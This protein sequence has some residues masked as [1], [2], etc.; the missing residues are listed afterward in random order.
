MKQ[1][2]TLLLLTCTTSLLILS[3]LVCGCSSSNSELLYSENFSGKYIAFLSSNELAV[4]SENSEGEKEYLVLDV[5]KKKC[6][7]AGDDRKGDIDREFIHLFFDEKYK[8]RSPHNADFVGLYNND[9]NHY[10]PPEE[11]LVKY[12]RT[13]Q[14]S[15]SR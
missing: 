13:F 3:A 6:T 12:P 1:L 2:I 7:A 4:C 10:I 9:P 15:G 8:L 11:P 14:G 5:S